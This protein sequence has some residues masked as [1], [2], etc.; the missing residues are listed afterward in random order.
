MKTS[1]AHYECEMLAKRE[2]TELTKKN[3]R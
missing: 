3:I 1:D 2:L